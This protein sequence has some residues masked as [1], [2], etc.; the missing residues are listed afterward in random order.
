MQRRRPAA[1]GTLFYVGA[2]LVVVTPSA[3]VA[4]AMIMPTN[5]RLSFVTGRYW[6]MTRRARRGPSPDG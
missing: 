6:G 3:T 1:V 4:A 2:I 5:A